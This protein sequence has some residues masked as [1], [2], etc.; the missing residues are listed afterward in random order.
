M[1]I[2]V[3]GGRYYDEAINKIFSDLKAI[4]PEDDSCGVEAEA[5]YRKAA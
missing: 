1:I 5:T 4:F 3:T 2:L